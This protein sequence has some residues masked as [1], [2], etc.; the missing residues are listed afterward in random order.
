MLNT[1]RVLARRVEKNKITR[2]KASVLKN[3]STSEGPICILAG[4]GTA[5][6]SNEAGRLGG[7]G[8]LF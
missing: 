6:L 4:V 3:I 5:I 7:G 1:I 8:E 2:S